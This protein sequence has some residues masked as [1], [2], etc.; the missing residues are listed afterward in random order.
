MDFVFNNNQTQEAVVYDWGLHLVQFFWHL[1]FWIILRSEEEVLGNQIAEYRIPQKLKSFIVL[2][3]Q[4]GSQIKT[5]LNTLIDPWFMSKSL[6]QPCFA[7][8]LVIQDLFNSFHLSLLEE[9]WFKCLVHFGLLLCELVNMHFQASLTFFQN[10]YFNQEVLGEIEA[11]SECDSA[12]NWFNNIG[13]LL[14][15][16]LSF[17]SLGWD[18]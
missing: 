8:K 15:V 16:K 14:E 3:P 11:T 12:S 9:N 6:N 1:T 18:V 17:R 2:N 5:V 10:A 7:L 4:V 13:K